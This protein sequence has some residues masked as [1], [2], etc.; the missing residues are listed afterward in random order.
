MCMTVR[1]L[2]AGHLEY[3]AKIGNTQ[4]TIKEVTRFL[5]L[6]IN[7]AVGD[8]RLEDLRMTDRAD[9][10]EAGRQYGIYGSQ[11]AVCYFKQLLEYATDL[12]F[13]IPFNYQKMELPKVPETRVEYL[14]AE[15]LNAIRNCFDVSDL[16]GLRTRALIELL[17]DTGLRIGE[18]TSLNKSDVNFDK[19]EIN[20]LNIKTK[21][22]GVVYMTDRSVQWLDLYMQ[23]RRDNHPAL[24][25]SGR[26]RLLSVTSRNYIRT[27][28][29]HLNIGKR[30]CH[31]VFRRT[32]GTTL[33][34]NQV[35]IKTVQD[36]LRHK[37]ERTTLRYYIGTNK[38]RSKAM[39]QDIM[40][41][42]YPLM[43]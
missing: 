7:Q 34:H 26:D 20:V 36:I 13:Q 1:D 41:T 31:H 19:K 25:I 39:H 38:A 22:W 29:K 27:K 9:V 42:V 14:S 15:D 37:S 4:K 5:G 3:R 33:A 23:A 18:A 35:D 24:F 8:K 10:I 43:A 11:R 40:S 28:T 12:G 32:L 16:Q 21:E 2:F 6:P 30:K 17:L